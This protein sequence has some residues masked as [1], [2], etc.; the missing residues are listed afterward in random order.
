MAFADA[1]PAH[2]PFIGCV[3]HLFQVGVGENAGRKIGTESADLNAL[4]LSQ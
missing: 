2:D 1:D 3:D 4:K